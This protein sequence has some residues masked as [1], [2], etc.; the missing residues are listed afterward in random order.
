M[1]YGLPAAIG[2]AFAR[3]EKNIILFCGDGG[4][5]TSIG[6][7]ETC[8]RYNLNIKIIVLK[9]NSYDLIKHYQ[10]KGNNVILENVNF[11]DI[12]YSKIAKAMGIN[13]YFVKNIMNFSKLFPKMIL[14]KGPALIEVPIFY[15]I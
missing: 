3:K 11:K 6:E 1:G 7:I 15:P 10:Q 9:N 8:R 14:E 12:S 13:G 4:G 2:I 5:L